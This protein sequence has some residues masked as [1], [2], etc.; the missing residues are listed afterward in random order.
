MEHMIYLHNNWDDINLKQTVKYIYHYT[1]KVGLDGIFGN[2]QLWANDIYRQNDKSEGIYVLNLLVENV[3]ILCSD[4]NVKEAILKQVEK[5]KPKLID[6]FYNS[7]KYRSFII[8][9]STESDE[10]ALWNYYTKDV[11]DSGYNIEFNVNILASQLSTV[12]YKQRENGGVKQYFD[13]IQ[14]KHGAVFYDK[15]EQLD[16][17]KRI[18]QEFSEYYCA[19]DDTWVYLLVDK[20]LWVGTF[21]KS[22]YFKHEYEYR[23]AFFTQ[24]D[25]S[26]LGTYNVPIEVEGTPKNH[27]EIYF[28]TTAVSSVYCSPTNSEQQIQYP[29]KYM[30]NY[31]PNFSSVQR[32]KIPFRII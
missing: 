28:D 3:D 27:I 30:T 15:K 1:S 4:N 14:C 5:L 26:M 8:S 10:L 25:K 29:K 7:T 19:V 2:Q 21:F 20:I 31:Y 32:S 11:N 24:T 13:K 22:P 18:I 23:F 17:L 12:K 16:I 9:F 6:G